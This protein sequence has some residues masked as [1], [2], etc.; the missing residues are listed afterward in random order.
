MFRAILGTAIVAGLAIGSASAAE[1][2]P[3]KHKDN[4]EEPLTLDFELIRKGKL[5]LVEPWRLVANK[6]YG[7]PVRGRITRNRVKEEK[8]IVTNTNVFEDWEL[9]VV[10]PHLEITREDVEVTYNLRY[11]QLTA[12]GTDERD[13]LEMWLDVGMKIIDENRPF[14]KG[15][16]T[17]TFELSCEWEFE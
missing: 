13:I 11:K 8:D 6:D 14:P 15:E 12:E 9:L 3:C 2:Y 16:Y 5:E 7:R 10:N 17:L 1:E 4:T